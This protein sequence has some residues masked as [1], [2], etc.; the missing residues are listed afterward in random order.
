MWKTRLKSI[1]FATAAVSGFI[2]GA[3]EKE[4]EQS[5]DL[6][7]WTAPSYIKILQN[8]DYSNDELYKDEYAEY[9][10]DS[11]L[12]IYMYRNEYEGGQIILSP[13]SDIQSYTLRVSDLTNENGQVLSKEQISVYNEKYVDVNI[14]SAS[15]NGTSMLGMTPDALL[16]FDKAIEYGENTVKAGENQG[17]YLEVN[18]Q[19]AKAGRYTGVCTLSVDGQTIQTPMNVTVWDVVVPTE[20]HMKS[21]FLLRTAE[22]AG[23]EL[24]STGKYYQTYFDKFLDYRINVINLPTGDEEKSLPESVEFKSKEDEKIRKYYAQLVKYYNDERVASIHF[25]GCENASWTNYD[26]TKAKDYLKLFAELSLAD[27][28]NYYTKLYYY[29]AIIDEPHITKTKS[30]VGPIFKLW[31]RARHAVIDEIEAGRETYKELYAVD[32]ALIDQVIDGI[33]H[34]ELLLTSS[35]RAEYTYEANKSNPENPA[36]EY[37][38]TWVPYMTAYD[39]KSGAERHTQE[40]VSEWWYGCDYPGTPAPTYHLDDR[41][42]SARALSWMAYKNNVVGN[43][44]WRVNYGNQYNSL[45]L[46]EPLEDPYDVT[47]LLHKTNGDGHLVYPGKPYGLD[48]FVPSMRLTAV[49]DGMEDFEIFKLT[50]NQCTDIATKAGYSEYDV[51]DVF[52]TL[53]STIFQGTTM[54]G[55]AS[56]MT[57]SRYALAQ[58]AEF[59]A[60][61]VIV[62]GVENKSSSTI[63]TVFAQNGATIKVNGVE[64]EYVQ[65]SEGKEYKIEIKQD[66]E[67]NVLSLVLEKDGTESQLDIN[68][69]GKKS[70]FAINELSYERLSKS[71]NAVTVIEKLPAGVRLSLGETTRTYHAF[72]IAG[73][74]MSQLL[75][76]G[77]KSIQVE[78]ENRGE[79]FKLEFKYTGTL[80]PI[81]KPIAASYTVPTGT[82][83]VVLEIGTIDWSKI[84]AMQTLQAHLTYSD[85]TAKEL[86]IKSI[87]VAY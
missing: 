23:T 74:Q 20:N 45:G 6:K 59:A 47:N 28:K 13:K 4:N 17:I 38:I 70:V 68:V 62:A 51:N 53:Y 44:Y 18:T 24:D 5:N 34:F 43:L 54:I 14:A 27:K 48:T 9:Y 85:K 78:V 15:H 72:T 58:Y 60:K 26:E 35:Y 36:E 8:I 11:T 82:S 16:P 64:P 12:D 71:A 52:E 65:K 1:F 50:G 57:I 63:V 80:D 66:K 29:L 21:A 75:R 33:E 79:P 7:I 32:D 40:E 83:L 86:M 25:P 61:G 55:K 56:D 73:A 81:V 3:C 42:I 46:S 39:T 22:L 19:G 49:R 37:V 84:G 67:Q 69:G 30:K 10:A 2:L 31:A 41:L 87:S 76:A 77:A